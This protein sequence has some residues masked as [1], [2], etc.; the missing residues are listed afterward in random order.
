MNRVKFLRGHR[1]PVVGRLHHALAS[2]Q[3]FDPKFP[4]DLARARPHPV[5]PRRERLA[6]RWDDPNP[7]PLR[8]RPT[9]PSTTRPAVTRY[10]PAEPL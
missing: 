3:Q 2:G 1:D 6:L 7:Q 10:P 5:N 8:Q 4:D 9:R